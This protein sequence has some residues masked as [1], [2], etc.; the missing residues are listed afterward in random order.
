MAIPGKISEE[1]RAD[2]LQ[3][4][5]HLVAVFNS[6]GAQNALDRSTP[7]VFPLTAGAASARAVTISFL[8]G[9]ALVFRNLDRITTDRPSAE[10]CLCLPPSYHFWSLPNHPKKESKRKIET[11][12]L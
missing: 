5:V 1:W 11:R 12:T 10:D 8:G 3:V 9:W 6:I 7:D 2:S 4:W